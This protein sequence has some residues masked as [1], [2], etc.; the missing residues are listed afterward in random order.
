MLPRSSKVLIPLTS[1]R[2]HGALTAAERWAAAQ[3]EEAL[4]VNPPR[5]RR[6]VEEM[7]WCRPATRP[8]AKG[9]RRVQEVVAHQSTRVSPPL[10]GVAAAQQAEALSQRVADKDAALRQLAEESGA[11]GAAGGLRFIVDPLDGTTNY[12]SGLPHFAV[13]IGVEDEEGLV[14]GAIYDPCR[15]EL[16]LAAR[17]CGA[18]RH[19]AAECGRHVRVRLSGQGAR[20]GRWH[21]RRRVRRSPARAHAAT[22]P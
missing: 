16:F 6:S 17:G 18:T 15:D 21:R 3:E 8:S 19:G 9:G 13:S 7:M 2:A 1:R 4:V 11:N 12:A 5:P 22:P 14:A 20:C 10:L